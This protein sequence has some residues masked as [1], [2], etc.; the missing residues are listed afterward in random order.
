MK[1]PSISDYAK[2]IFE[3]DSEAYKLDL[4]DKMIYL[5]I[6]LRFSSPLS[7]K[8]AARQRRYLIEIKLFLHGVDE[9]LRKLGY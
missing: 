5:F 1:N 4:L 3:Y 8:E 7:N 6:G 9:E 2:K